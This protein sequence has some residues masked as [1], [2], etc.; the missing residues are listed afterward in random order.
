MVIWTFGQSDI[1]EM[2]SVIVVVEDDGDDSVGHYCQKNGDG[3]Q[4]SL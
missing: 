3:Q 1:D 4:D 2:Q